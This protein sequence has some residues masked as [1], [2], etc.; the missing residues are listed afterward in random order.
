MQV[1]LKILFLLVVVAALL[2]PGCAGTGQ[3]DS[4]STA[5]ASSSADMYAG[6]FY[7]GFERHANASRLFNNA[8]S[9]WDDD[10]Y[11]TAASLLEQ[12]RGEYALAGGLY[13]N[14]A[15]YASNEGELAFAEAMEEAVIDMD[16]A[17]SRYLMS[18]DEALADNDTA[19]LEYFQEGQA[20]VDR[21]M[22]ALNRS[23]DYMPS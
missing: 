10:D 22:M 8:T 21:S 23:L 20:L 12:A 17:S 6:E 14:M 16:E 3:P 2:T 13:H 19:S 4:N 11:A 1:K 18:I 15:A 9:H 5:I 7:S